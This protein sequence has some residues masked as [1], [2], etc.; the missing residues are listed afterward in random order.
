MKKYNNFNFYLKFI[1]SFLQS[2]LKNKTKKNIDIILNKVSI[3]NNIQPIQV[4]YVIY[5]KLSSKFGNFSTFFFLLY[6]GGKN[7][8]PN[9]DGAKV[10]PQ[11][12]LLYCEI[13]CCG[14]TATTK[15]LTVFKFLHIT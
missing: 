8:P 5:S 10:L 9:F 13:Y 3:K 4:L 12:E 14:Y 11:G 1:N 2:G 7:A 15:T 6:V